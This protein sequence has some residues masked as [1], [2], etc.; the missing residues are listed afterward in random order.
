MLDRSDVRRDVG[1]AVRHIVVQ[2]TAFTI[3]TFSFDIVPGA[4]PPKGFRAKQQAWAAL[5]QRVVARL[6]ADSS[7]PEY[8]LLELRQGDAPQTLGEPLRAVL[9]LFVDRIIEAN[10][11]LQATASAAGG[12]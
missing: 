10:D 8:H 9:N 5:L 12:Q 4:K 7:T 2:Y 3:D 1:L 11:D 6:H